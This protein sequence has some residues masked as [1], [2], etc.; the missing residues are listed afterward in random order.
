MDDIELI[1]S[2][3]DKEYPQEDLISISY[4]EPWQ[5]SGKS[6]TP[7]LTNFASIGSD[8]EATESRVEEEDENKDGEFSPTDIDPDRFYNAIK[9]HV[10]QQNSLQS[11]DSLSLG[12][13]IGRRCFATKDSSV[14]KDSDNDI[15][16]DESIDTF[17]QVSHFA[18]YFCLETK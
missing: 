14:E 10:T 13:N 16:P 17:D 3:D 11:T 15:R 8:Q 1:F 9:E 6:G 12:D 2:S 18:R 4:Y 7:I 5:K